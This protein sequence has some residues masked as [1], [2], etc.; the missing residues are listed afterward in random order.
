MLRNIVI[1]VFVALVGFAAYVHFQPAEYSVSRSAFFT[2]APD[3]VFEQINNLNKWEKWSPWAAMD[4]EQKV[5]FEGPL[6]GV[7]ATMSWEGKETGVGTM[8]ITTSVPHERIEM[9]LDFKK[10]MEATS[11]SV[12]VF[13]PE[14]GGTK[15]TWTTSGVNNFFGKAFA[16]IMN[17][18]KCLGDQFVEGFDNIRKIVEG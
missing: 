10:P 18:D 13:E 15:V 7:G 14:G 16:V 8:K 12:F 17:M 6:A 5:T 3:T 2:A 9:Q 1:L 4:P 11:Q